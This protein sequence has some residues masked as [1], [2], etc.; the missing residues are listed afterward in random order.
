MIENS[1]ILLL[2]FF[3][4]DL[5]LH[6]LGQLKFSSIPPFVHSLSLKKASNLW[7]ILLNNNKWSTN[8]VLF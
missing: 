6:F 2:R 8:N 7:L 1:F 3:S 5:K 4:T